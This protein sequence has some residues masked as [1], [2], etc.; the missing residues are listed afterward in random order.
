MSH[1]LQTP[2]DSAAGGAG[3]RGH[4]SGCR[5]STHLRPSCGQGQEEG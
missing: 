5:M 1:P 2:A 3:C 4:R